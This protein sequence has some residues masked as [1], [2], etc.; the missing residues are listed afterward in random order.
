MISIL[1][2]IYNFDV[3][4]LVKNLHQ[5]GCQLAVD[6]EIICVDDASS[7]P[8][9]HLNKSL[10]KLHQV[11]LEL[12]AQNMG[13]AAI[14]NYLASKA[15]YPYLLFM[16][17]DSKPISHQYLA[18]YIGQLA[19]D[20]LLYG[21]RCY[22]ISAPLDPNLYFHWHYGTKRESTTAAYRK[23]QPYRSFM[24]NNFLIPAAIF[25]TIKFD[26]TLQQYGH[27]DTLFGLELKKYNISIVHLDNPLE[28]IG[29]EDFARF[30]KKSE[31]AIENLVQLSKQHHLSPSVR[32]VR[33]YELLRRCKCIS[34]VS[35]L[36][37]LLEKTLKLHFK[38]KPVYLI[39]FDLYKLIYYTQ[40]KK[41][42]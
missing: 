17:G 36:G 29:I 1:I 20:K 22:Q 31:Q 7:P 39:L 23:Q 38:R 11:H 3:T 4:K 24:T 27:E 2:P 26:E 8:F 34:I 25:R 19:P 41:K 5:Q 12:L 6:F 14:R 37:I 16:D 32:L 40:L 18:N 10:T 33:Y 42:G 21:G 15:K 28:H 13:R 30:I 9:V 35:F